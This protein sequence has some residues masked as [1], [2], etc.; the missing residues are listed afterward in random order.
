MKL[1][2]TSRQL[3][4]LQLDS[5]PLL[6]HSL[7]TISLGHPRLPLPDQRV[8][9]PAALPIAISGWEPTAFKHPVPRP[10]DEIGICGPGRVWQE[11][12]WWGGCK[13][14]VE[15]AED[16]VEV[17]RE[18]G[19]GWREPVRVVVK[20]VREVRECGGVF[21]FNEREVVS[22]RNA[23]CYCTLPST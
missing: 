7:N 8:L 5:L 4:I 18:V 14:R 6:H 23:L 19:D 12:F 20:K 3:Y 10:K 22:I 9:L 21:C 17:C 15:C 1:P 11:V 13:G 2:V 16:Y